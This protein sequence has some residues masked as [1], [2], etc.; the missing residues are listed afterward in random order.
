MEKIESSM[1]EAVE[2]D[3]DKLYIQFKTGKVYEYEGVNA[4]SYSAFMQADSKGKYFH[5]NF[6][7]LP[8]KR[9]K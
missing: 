8:A 5:E 4:E 7:H 6:A 3:G 2:Y 1:I 9:I